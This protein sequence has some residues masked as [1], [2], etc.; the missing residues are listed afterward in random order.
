VVDE[1][2]N[3]FATKL[4]LAVALDS[5]ELQVKTNVEDELRPFAERMRE[6]IPPGE[7]AFSGPI[8]DELADDMPGLKTLLRKYRLT[9]AAFIDKFPGLITRDGRRISAA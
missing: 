8:Q 9:T 7:R 2:G 6:L 5:S 3:D 1:D 4:V